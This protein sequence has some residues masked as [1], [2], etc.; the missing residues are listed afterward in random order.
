MTA[1]VT[2]RPNAVGAED[3]VLVNVDSQGPATSG[4][5]HVGRATLVSLYGQNRSG[6]T[7]YIHVHAADAVPAD[8]A[9]PCALPIPVAAGGL[10]AF[11]PAGG[12]HGATGL[13]WVSSTSS[14]TTTI[15]GVAD[16]W[17]TAT[18]EI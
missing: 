14:D 16:V 4:V 9:V 3:A 6:S 8:G 18:V 13:C 7:R 5:L 1:L 2:P 12:I 15:T 11:E 10:F 17:L